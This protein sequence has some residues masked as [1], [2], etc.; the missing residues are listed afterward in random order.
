MN[1]YEALKAA[2]AESFMFY[3]QAHFFHW[4]VEGPT[5]PQLHKLFGDIYEDMDGAM[6]GLAEHIR[7][8]GEYT[9]VSVAELMAGA[10]IV[11]DGKPDAD[12]MVAKL[13]SDNEVVKAALEAANEVAEEAGHPGIAN[14]LQERIDQH[15]KWGWFLKATAQKPQTR[16]ERSRVLYDGKQRGM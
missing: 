9:P 7:T 10:A 14:Y 12:G 11:A 1:C 2:L 4:N 3:M 5:F 16:M 6:D 15:A 8:L 13:A